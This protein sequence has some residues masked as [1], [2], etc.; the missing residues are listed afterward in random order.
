MKPIIVLILAIVASQSV[1]AQQIEYKDVH[2][3]TYDASGNRTK[4]NLLGVYDCSL[5]PL[6]QLKKENAPPSTAPDPTA[7]QIG[8]MEHPNPTTDVLNLTTDIKVPITSSSYILTDMAGKQY[9]LGS[10]LPVQGREIIDIG[11]LNTGVYLLKVIV[12]DKVYTWQV[13]KE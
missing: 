7:E 6:E 5:D 10:S 1:F 11:N 8:M 3:Y 2:K 4:R 12:N 9:R 13:V